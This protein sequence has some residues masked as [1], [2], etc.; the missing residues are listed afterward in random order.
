MALVELSLP[1]LAAHVRTARL[2]VVAAARRAGLDDAL[3]DE[4]RLALGEAC[5]RAVGLHAKHAPAAPV[6]VTV[7][8]DASGLT[9]TVTDQGPAAEPTSGDLARDM[10][11]SAGDD[12]IDDVVDPD[13]ALAVLSGLVD[14]CTIEHTGAGTTVT[15]RWP[16]PPRPVGVGGPGATQVSQV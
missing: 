4:L 9:I 6:L 8:D 3:V 5:S 10:L 12:A 16:L 14:D 7:A 11:D 13:V 2:V 15:M 1:P